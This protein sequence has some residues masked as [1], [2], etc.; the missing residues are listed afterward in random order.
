MSTVPR[1]GLG[2]SGNDDPAQCADSV[3][4]ALD[5]GY[6]HIDTAQMYDNE[7]AVGDGIAKSDVPREEVFLATKV[8]PSNLGFDDVHAS[9]ESSLDR[10]GVDT[11]DLLYVHWPTQAYDPDAT[12]R[13]FDELYEAGT[14][15]HVGVSNFT[16]ELIEEAL[17]IL[18][19]PIVANQ[20]EVHPLLGPREPLFSTC[21]DHDIDI[22]AYAPFCRGEALND[23]TVQAVAD[24]HDSSPAQVCLAW[25]ASH[26]VAAIPKATGRA[27]I[28]ANARAT[29]LQ[30]TD[31]DIDRLDR[32]DRR[33][34][35]F[36][37]DG[38]PWSE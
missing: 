25:L 36:D 11:I 29:A 18:D 12:L 21:R 16:P 26:D 10:L 30:L 27:H 8:H 32:I 22:V 9:T 14:I 15:D 4:T 7:T 20:V 1:L 38:S 37:P 6:R 5:A 28:E 24:A 3:A 17:T 13:A 35:R 2:T 31:D 33:Y 23:P 19:A 34:R